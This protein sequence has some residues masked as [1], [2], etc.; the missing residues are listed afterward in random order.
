MLISLK[1]TRIADSTNGNDTAPI[2]FFI[3][4]MAEEDGR[5]GAMG[6]H[7]RWGVTN[8]TVELPAGRYDLEI[9]Q[10]NQILSESN[11]SVN[12]SFCDLNIA[13]EYLEAKL[14]YFTVTFSRSSDVVNEADKDT[15]TASVC[16]S[17]HVYKGELIGHFCTGNSLDTF[18]DVS[19]RNYGL[20]QTGGWM[21]KLSP[22]VK[23]QVK[24]SENAS[25]TDPMRIDMTKRFDEG[26]DDR[27]LWPDTCC[28][29]QNLKVH[30]Y[31]TTGIPGYGI[32]EP[33]PSDPSHI[34]HPDYLRADLEIHQASRIGSEGCVS[35][36]DAAKWQQLRC[37]MDSINT[38]AYVPDLL[39]TYAGNQPDPFRHPEGAEV[40]VSIHPQ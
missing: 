15:E 30:T 16:S 4:D 5:R 31:Q 14:R 35:V 39:I 24:T 10:T 21:A 32:D 34:N 36:L 11:A 6:G 40:D 3:A 26:M 22:W 23:K 28:P 27:T 1:A 17:G 2:E 13:V 7:T 8:E 12:V 38:D 20:V 25:S 33:E 18:I 29:G 9:S 19:T 37:D